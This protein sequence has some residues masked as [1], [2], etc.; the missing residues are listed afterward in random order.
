MTHERQVEEI[1]FGWDIVAVCD[2]APEAERLCSDQ[3]DR[4]ALWAACYGRIYI[5]RAPFP[6]WPE[7]LSPS[8]SVRLGGDQGKNN[9]CS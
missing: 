4:A 6:A 5:F 8:L 2:H 1:P 3:G 9:A 7:F